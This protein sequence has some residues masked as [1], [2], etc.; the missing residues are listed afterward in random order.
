MTR[1]HTRLQL[2]RS[3]RPRGALWPLFAPGN[4]RHAKAATL[5]RWHGVGTGA[6]A[7]L[8]LWTQAADDWPSDCSRSERGAAEVQCVR[9]S[10]HFQ[11]Y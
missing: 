5:V 1:R 6:A 4:R 7:I 3:D 11:K 10:G 9:D 2:A 8:A